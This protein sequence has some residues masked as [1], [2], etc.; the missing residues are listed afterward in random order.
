M[1]NAVQSKDAIFSLLQM[2]RS[3][4]D[5]QDLITIFTGENIDAKTLRK[6]AW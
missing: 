1:G 3:K 4:I 2:N 5:M 6:S